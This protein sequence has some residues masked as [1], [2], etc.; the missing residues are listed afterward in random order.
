MYYLYIIQSEKMGKHYTGVT[1]DLES[2]LRQ[3]NSGKTRSTK[4]G[5]PWRLIYSEHFPTR[6]DA[7]AR[8][9]QVKSYRGGNA[10]KKLLNKEC[11]RG[12]PAD[13]G[14][15]SALAEGG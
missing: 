15:N 3:H 2:R 4:S 6:G 7:I 8:E 9:R 14:V 12:A 5:I 11:R 10:F 13:G 1:G